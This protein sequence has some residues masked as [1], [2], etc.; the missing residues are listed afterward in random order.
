MT[1]YKGLAPKFTRSVL[2]QAIKNYYRVTPVFA[3]GKTKPYA[4]GETYYSEGDYA[5]AV[6]MA[7][8]LGPDL[9]LVDYDANKAA[10]D[11]AELKR[12]ELDGDQEGI[13][14]MIAVGRTGKIL[15][16]PDLAT[17][18]GI[19]A[20]PSVFQRNEDGDSLHY[21]F[22][23]PASINIAELKQSNDGR[24]L[25]YIDIKRG[26][27]LCHLKPH[28]QLPMG[29]PPLHTLLKAPSALIEALKVIS[30]ITN[31]SSPPLAWDGS[32]RDV[33][34]AREMLRF[35]DPNKGYDC[36]IKVL[37]AIYSKFGQSEE[38]V[39]LADDWSQKGSTYNG[40]HEIEY[41][42]STFDPLGLVTFAT[43][44]RLAKEAGADISEINRK[45]NI[46][47]SAKAT[48][49]GVLAKINELDADSSS[50]AIKSVL[51]DVAGLHKIE[52]AKAIKQIKGAT[53][54]PISALN[55]QVKELQSEGKAENDDS[56]VD[57]LTLSQRL[58]QRVGEDNVLSHKNRLYLW[59]G[60]VWRQQE[61]VGLN[62][63]IQQFL[64][65]KD[66]SV[67]FY[68]VKS[69]SQLLEAE[70]YIEGHRFNQGPQ[71]TVNL[72]N[73]EMHI[74]EG[75]L[76]LR[77]HERT[78]YNSIQIPHIFDPSA[79]APRFVAFLQE[80]FSGDADCQD[81]STAVLEAFGYTLMNHCRY[82]KFFICVGNGSNGK[83]VLLNVL[84]HVLSAKNHCSI[85]P[86]KFGHSFSVA[87]LDGRLANIVSE[88][89]AK[90]V[91]PDDMVK[92]MASGEGVQV[93]HKNKDPFTLESIATT[94]VAAN[95]LPH[96]ADVS[97]ALFRR[98][99]VFEFNNMFSPSDASHDVNL[100]DKL[101]AEACGIIRL[102]L[103][104]YAKATVSDFTLPA[105]SRVAI[106]AWREN[107][108]QVREFITTECEVNAE[109]KISLHALFRSYKEWHIQEQ[110]SAYPVAR[111]EFSKRVKANG[112]SHSRDK[113]GF[114]FQ[115]LTTVKAQE[116][117]QLCAN[118]G[119]GKSILALRAETHTSQIH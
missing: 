35:I 14:A 17:K 81:K 93:E 7:L 40:V 103:K 9:I 74:V 66:V 84:K 70:V 55:E 68:R 119:R 8:I 30:Y 79:T 39:S 29:L 42:F 80:V 32:A 62:Q 113:H 117:L 21:L 95:A 49:A 57:D 59:A 43:L 104:A 116:V 118:S 22:R 60:G 52:A 41:K 89:P 20:M 48:E 102:A 106:D 99:V 2:E 1:N 47:G 97:D 33:S 82:E 109:A 72:L 31:R 90:S 85:S 61:P 75:R 54:L 69:V 78:H 44:V 25:P 10:A 24:F 4:S 50:D 34:E 114:V 108:D 67:N 83:S 37:M 73:G 88:L 11:A 115:G 101:K 27:Q 71:D 26:N 65:N 96:S 46:D 5:D 76:T 16:P 92:I 6:A 77:S 87:Q 111:R 12:R 94:W 105:S 3:N 63:H 58:I 110:P 36:W 107:V 19:Q 86:S 13:D 98:A 38:G 15:S 45:F 53:N 51:H 64:S 18:F 112:F 28:K 100:I 91:L 56:S 23:L